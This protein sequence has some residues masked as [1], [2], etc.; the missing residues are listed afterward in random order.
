MRS[1]PVLADV[2]VWVGKSEPRRSSTTSASVS[3]TTAEHHDAIAAA[4]P[5]APT[6]QQSLGEHKQLATADRPTTKVAVGATTT[7]GASITVGGPTQPS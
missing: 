6:V 3:K 5:I 2:K 7:S 4:R 1:E